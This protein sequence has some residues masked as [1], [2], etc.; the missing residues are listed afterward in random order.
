MRQFTR[1]STISQTVYHTAKEEEE[2]EEE[3]EK[4]AGTKKIH[5]T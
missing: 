2:E 1:H 5:S 4:E 3:E